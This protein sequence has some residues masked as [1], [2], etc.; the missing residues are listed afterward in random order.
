MLSTEVDEH[1]ELMDRVLVFREERCRRARRKELSRERSSPLLRRERRESHALA[2]PLRCAPPVHVRRAPRD[3]PAGRQP[4]RPAELRRARATGPGRWRPGAVRDRRDGRPRRSCRAA[5]DWICRSGR[6]CA[7]QRDPRRAAS[8]PTPAG[9]RWVAMPI[10]LRSARRSARSTARSSRSSATA[11]HRG[12]CTFF[13]L[14]GM[15]QKIL[16]SPKPPPGNWTAH[17]GGKVGPIPGALI[18]MARPAGHLARPAAHRRTTATVRRRR[19]RRDGVRA[20]ASTSPRSAIVAYALGG[21]FAAIA[22]MALT[23]G[24]PVGRP[25][26]RLQYTLDRDRRRGA[27]RHAV[28]RRPRRARRRAPRRDVHLPHPE[29]PRRRSSVEWLDVVYGCVLIGGHP[30]LAAAAAR[31]V[32]PA[33]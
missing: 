20:P 12:L 5:A 19:R 14:T 1:V 22:G 21:L 15:T 3:R 31:L 24:D 25:E 7:D 30:L 9:R 29:P 18:P 28:G 23:A 6:C 13:V 10:L 27:R 17:L 4:H 26:P 2:E 8:S 32:G 33:R 11:D 16:P